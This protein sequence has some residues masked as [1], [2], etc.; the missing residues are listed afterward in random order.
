MIDYLTLD[1]TEFSAHSNIYE[2]IERMQAAKICKPVAAYVD[3]APLGRIC[4]RC[5]K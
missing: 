2:Q 5:R 3:D 1:Y 4:A